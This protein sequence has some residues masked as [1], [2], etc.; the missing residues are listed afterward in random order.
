MSFGDYYNGCPPDPPDLYEE[1]CVK[2]ECEYLDDEG[3]CVK[4][5]CP[6]DCADEEAEIRVGIKD[7]RIERKIDERRMK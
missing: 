6:E 1:I 3:E 5:R 4:N 2:R 7:D